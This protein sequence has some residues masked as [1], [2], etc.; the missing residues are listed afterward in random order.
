MKRIKSILSFILVF[1]LTISF[2]PSTGVYAKLF[3]SGGVKDLPE[4]TV[5][6]PSA[7][8]DTG[9]QDF[10]RVSAIPI[11]TGSD[12]V[13]PFLSYSS[14]SKKVKL[15]KQVPNYPEPEDWWYFTTEDKS[16]RAKVLYQGSVRTSVKVHGTDDDDLR[17][18]M[19][20]IGVSSYTNDWAVWDKAIK[21]ENA[22]RTKGKDILNFLFEG[23]YDGKT[24]YYFVF[25]RVKVFKEVSSSKTV[26]TLISRQ[27]YRY[28]Q[29]SRNHIY[30]MLG[31]LGTL[32]DSKKRLYDNMYGYDYK[33]N[34]QVISATTDGWLNQGNEA[35]FG[36]G[37][38]TGGNGKY[39]YAVYAGTVYPDEDKG[40]VVLSVVAEI[41]ADPGKKGVIV[42]SPAL[43]RNQTQRYNFEVD[44]Y[45]KKQ[46]LYE[47]CTFF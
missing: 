15:H 38:I 18:F 4:M 7:I 19:K 6:N 8:G 10:Y 3:G 44:C 45:V 14:K 41:Q 5:A 12:A 22:Q 33:L 34:G 42:R 28:S 40:N 11:D 46:W 23:N 2:L 32:S 36:V 39:G 21:K 43:L 35:P 27:D 25:E 16:K 1:F 9:L 13:T 31:K 17:K 20:I 47:G 24:K 37:F 29:D 26:Y 30:A